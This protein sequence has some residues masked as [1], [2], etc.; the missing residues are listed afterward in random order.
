MKIRGIK[1]NNFI[2]KLYAVNYLF[3]YGF[4]REIACLA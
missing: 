1:N 3:A 2:L 4:V